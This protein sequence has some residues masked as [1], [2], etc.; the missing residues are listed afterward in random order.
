MVIIKSEFVHLFEES[1]ETIF[2]LFLI[3]FKNVN[4]YSIYKFSDRRNLCKAQVYN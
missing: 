4:V 1:L 3:L 2:V